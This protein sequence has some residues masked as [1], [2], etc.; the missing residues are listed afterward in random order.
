MGFSGCRSPKF[1]QK[2]L[3]GAPLRAHSNLPCRERLTQTAVL[4]G[5]RSYRRQRIDTNKR[6]T[7][8]MAHKDYRTHN[9]SVS[10]S[11]EEYTIFLERV[12]ASGLTKSKYAREVLLKESAKNRG[13]FI[14][15]LNTEIKPIGRNLNSAY[16]AIKQNGCNTRTLTKLDYILQEFET[17]FHRF[18]QEMN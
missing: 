15:T 14:K 10:F 2:T 17:F 1:P 3:N 18:L 5:R 8:D 13:D 7:K 11:D 16:M 9:F 6:K 4:R 12:D